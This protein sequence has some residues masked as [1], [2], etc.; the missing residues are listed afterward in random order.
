M[1]PI[2]PLTTTLCSPH[3]VLI[4]YPSP[5]IYRAMHFSAKRG[6]AITLCRPSVR[7]VGGL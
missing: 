1:A 7:D 2:A 4:F 3:A 5:C 6:R